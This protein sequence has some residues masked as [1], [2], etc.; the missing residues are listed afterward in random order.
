MKAKGPPMTPAEQLQAAVEVL[1]DLVDDYGIRMSCPGAS[2]A[3]DTIESALR[4]REAA[5]RE[6]L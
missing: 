3:L 4:E 6:A 1:R 5:E 2:T